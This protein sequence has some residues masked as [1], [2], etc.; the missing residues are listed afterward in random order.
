MAV[1]SLTPYP[2]SSLATLTTRTSSVM[3]MS[4]SDNVTE[5][6]VQSGLTQYVWYSAYAKK[7]WSVTIPDLT[8]SERDMLR[9]FWLDR[10]GRAVPFKWINKSE[11]WPAG[12]LYYVRFGTKEIS[13]GRISPTHWN[14]TMV[15]QEAHPLE[16]DKS[17]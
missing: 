13:F 6:A 5:F 8:L 12:V 17:S 3:Q 7:V 16:I 1:P 10:Y 14:C 4:S 2:A 15:L 11:Q 9:S